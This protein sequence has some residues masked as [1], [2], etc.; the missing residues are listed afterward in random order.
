M[1]ATEP[2]QNQQALTTLK[3]PLQGRLSAYGIVLGLISALAGIF[4]VES[5]QESLSLASV[6]FGLGCA[7][8]AFLPARASLLDLHP[9]PKLLAVPLALT[10]A[11][12]LWSVCLS[13]SSGAIPSWE[14]L[15]IKWFLAVLT[16]IV[17]LFLV[18]GVVAWRL[19]WVDLGIAAGLFG[20]ALALR[21]YMLITRSPISIED[22]IQ[23][24]GAALGVNAVPSVSPFETLNSFTGLWYWIVYF[25]YE[26]VRS[27]FDKYSFEKLL[28]ASAGAVSVPVW[29]LV[30]RAFSSR[31]VALCSASLL[32]FLGWHWL[33]SRLLYIYPVDLA[34]ISLATLCAVSSLKNGNLG[35]AG[36]A[37]ALSGFI[38]VTQRIGVMT[39]PLIGYLLIDSFIIGDIKKRRA[40]L[41][42]GVTWLASLVFVFLP[43]F[44]YVSVNNSG[45]GLLPRHSLMATGRAAAIAS[46]GL[47]E[48]SAFFLIAKDVFQQL[49]VSESD[50]IRHLFRTEGPI[51]DPIFS[52]LFILGLF[53][54]ARRAPSQQ[55][56]RF[57]FV[58]LALFSLPMILSFPADGGVT[59]GLARRML[60]TCFFVAGFAGVGAELLSQRLF[61]PRRQAIFLIV[62]CG[63]SCLTNISFFFSSYMPVSVVGDGTTDKDLGIQRAS[64]IQTVRRLAATGLDTLYLCDQQPT[65]K[66]LNTKDIKQALTDLPRAQQVGSL[67]ALRDQLQAL[68]GKPV[69]VVVPAS[70]A[71]LPKVYQEIPNQLVDIIPSYLWMPGPEDQHGIPTLWYAFLYAR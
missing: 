60:G 16:L 14:L 50:A 38:L 56:A 28:M 22:E 10:S 4:L 31:T 63:A 39:L 27:V 53:V 7:L 69:F 52:S 17:A 48:V 8:L 58:G 47:T 6:L 1:F 37:G 26:P 12:L 35:L 3:P 57:L 46:T 9:N 15:T 62:L 36:L 67:Q 11:V 61:T 66:M 65:P 23:V 13:V 71:T 64:T 20:V 54:A 24:F 21:C 42:I 25:L 19:C 68:A 41:S 33:N 43:V 30:I 18:S 59:R 55:L 32:C 51:L 44:L 29:F 45:E 49:L 70:T 34:L 2:H 40:T 5:N